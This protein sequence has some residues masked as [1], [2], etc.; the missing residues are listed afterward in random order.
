MKKFTH[1]LIA[2]VLCL[3]MIGGM[4]PM[5]SV[6][7]EETEAAAAEYTLYPTPHEIAYGEGSFELTD[8][9]VAYGEGIDEY[10]EARLEEPAAL[11]D[12]SVTESE[13]A[14][15]YVAIYG[16]GDAVEAYILENYTVDVSL[17]AKTDANFVAVNDGEIVVLGKDTDSAFYGLTTLYQIFGQMEGKTIRNLTIN[18]YA[19]V[20]S[21]GFIEGYYGNPWSVEDRANLMTWGGYY[22]LNSYFYAPKDDPKHNAKRCSS[23]TSFQ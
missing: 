18:D 11:L 14:N 2:L 3:V 19:D 15:V 1:K 6:H 22:K 13:D 23:T 4:L 21:R 5:V 9:K 17:F 7:A 10:T 12:L 8:L 16:S 20:A